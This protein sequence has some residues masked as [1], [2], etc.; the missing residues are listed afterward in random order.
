MKLYAY[1]LKADRYSGNR[2][3][4]VVELEVKECPR[5][6][7]IIGEIPQNIYIPNR[8]SKSDVNGFITTYYCRGKIVILDHPDLEVAKRIFF[9][10]YDGKIRESRSRTEWLESIKAVINDYKEGEINV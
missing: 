7:A 6:Y 9:D 10:F 2:S 1:V 4:D 8:F 3:F 5:T